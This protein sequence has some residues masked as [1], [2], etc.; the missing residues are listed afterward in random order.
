MNRRT[1]SVIA[2]TMLLAACGSTTA[3]SDANASA[4]SSTAVLEVAG[5]KPSA[6]AQ[7]I[8]AKEAQSDIAAS[9]GLEPS[10]VTKPSWN[11]AEHIYSCDYDYGIGG[12]IALSVKELSSTAETTS[13]FDTLG[14]R[15]GRGRGLDIAQG[16]FPTNN[17]SFVVRKDYKV[18]LIDVSDLPAQFG[19]P[20]TSQRVR[21]GQYRDCDH[22]VLERH[23]DQRPR[24]SPPT[25]HAAT[26]NSR[27]VVPR[28]M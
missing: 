22:G 28:S 9:V 15:L 4:P 21:R 17:G 16:S 7:M 20:P 8:C 5:P 13:Y 14:G 19:V 24:T 25:I 23:I 26:L 1:T 18:L 12:R 11:A 10:N 27:L 3:T 2:I 6:S